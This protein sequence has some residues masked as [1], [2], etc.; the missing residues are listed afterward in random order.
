MSKRTPHLLIQDM[1]DSANK[2]LEYTK[3]LSYDDFTADSKTV[4]AVIRNF[5]I[6]GEAA[7]RLPEDFR[8]LHPSIDWTRI[9]GFRN[10]I[11]HDYF[12]ID[13]SIV[14]QIKGTYLIQL[15]EELNK[16]SSEVR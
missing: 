1:L 12:G 2:I 10:R 16:I 6:I 14:W 7:S 4:D 13:Y 5:E 11:V 15:I 3:G 8:T 9:R